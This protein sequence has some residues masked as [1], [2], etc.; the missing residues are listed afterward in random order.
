[1][2]RRTLLKHL[3][4]ASALPL[5]GGY[6]S[7]AEGTTARSDDPFLATNEDEVRR[8]LFGNLSASESADVHLSIPIQG[9]GRAIPVEVSSE[10]QDVNR[11]AIVVANNRH[12]L[13]AVFVPHPGASCVFSTRIR[14]QHTS[15]VSAYAM[16]DRGLLVTRGNVKITLGGYGSGG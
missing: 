12:P 15:I 9:D 6:L 16:T 13:C 2:N 10:L 4:T 8:L 7:V 11:F 3:L 5:S 14:M 1:M